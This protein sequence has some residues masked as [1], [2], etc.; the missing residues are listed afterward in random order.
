MD[1]AEE[2]AILKKE[3]GPLV[4]GEELLSFDILNAKLT[5]RFDNTETSSEQICDAVSRTG[6][7]ARAWG[8]YVLDVEQKSSFWMRNKQLVAC[9]LSGLFILTA[10]SLHASEHGALDAFSGSENSDHVFPTSVIILY[11][12]GIVAGGWFIF[13]KAVSALLRFRPDMHLLMA[14]AVIGASLIGEWFEAAAVTFLFGVAQL[15]ESWSVERARKAIRSLMELSPTKALYKVDNEQEFKEAIADEVPIGATVLVKPGEK[16]PLDGTILKGATNINEAPITGESMPVSKDI[17]DSVFAG[18]INGDSAFEFRVTKKAN[19]TTL[20]R[21]IRMVEEAQSRRAP[22]EQWVEKFARYY[23]PS[24]MILALLVACIPPLFFGAIWGESIYRGLVLLVIACPCALVIS[25][26]VSIV[27]GLSSA[28]KAGVLIKGGVFL[29]KAAHIKALALDKTGTLT[30]GHPEVQMVVPFNDHSSEE[31][32]SIAASLEASSEHPLARAILR[33]AKDESIQYVPAEGFS[34]LKGRGAQGFI[35][36]SLFWIG[37]HRF[38]HE[39][40]LETEEIHNQALK[41]QDAGQTV[42]VIGN[43]QHVCG[44]ISIADSIRLDA[45]KSIADLKQIG[46]EEIIM[47]TGDNEG[48]AKAISALSGVDSF[49]AELLPED[50]VTAITEL[51]SEYQN[52]AMIGD[53][54]NDAP[55]LAVAS[56]GIAMGAAGTDAAI[57]TADIALMSDELSKLPWLIKHSRRTLG[58]IKQNIIFSLGIKLIFLVLTFLG[59]ATLW[60]AI[61]ADA[62]ASLL[63]VFNGLRLLQN[64]E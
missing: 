42:V 58:V 23:T 62:G 21:I 50:K 25:T 19:D 55:A 48:T 20:S 41:F 37:S 27:S 29:E 44:L 13:P 18:T 31:L 17:S 35:D 10:F 5:V 54:V 30:Q 16:I 45:A 60:M 33:R 8:E 52:V 7:L 11:L 43:E 40:S 6:M 32:L 3:L 9:F 15:L 59:M 14:V 38:L 61:A 12:L 56:L 34:I 26:P 24:M 2:V 22:S 46:I 39:K 53:G 49:K 63:V 57:E 36:G 47:L 1:C 51:V 64:H 4:G 28:A